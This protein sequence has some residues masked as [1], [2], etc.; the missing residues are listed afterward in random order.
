M[1]VWNKRESFA[2][3]N[4]ESLQKKVPKNGITLLFSYARARGG[5]G[6]GSTQRGK[7]KSGDV[8]RR[9]YETTLLLATGPEH[10]RAL[11]PNKCRFR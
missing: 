11:Y 8:K 2:R 7:F 4:A 5:R 6:G 3:V 10:E 9:P 1:T